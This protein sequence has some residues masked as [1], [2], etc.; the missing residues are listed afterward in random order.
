MRASLICSSHH[1]PSMN[2]AIKKT[3]L[4]VTGVSLF[5]DCK[6]RNRGK[7]S[8]ALNFTLCRGWNSTS[9]PSI[10]GVRS[11]GRECLENTIQHRK[12]WGTGSA[13]SAALI[14]MVS[15]V[16]KLPAW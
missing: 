4:Q 15:K 7:F 14:L 8:E 13:E 9:V 11:F 16:P 3:D 5:L 1:T 6:T 10:I 2:F 12:K